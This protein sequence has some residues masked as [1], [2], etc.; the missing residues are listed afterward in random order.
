MLS[1][2]L[3]TYINPK[4]NPDKYDEEESDDPTIENE[5]EEEEEERDDLL[6]M[7]TLEEERLKIL[8]PNY[9]FTRFPVLFAQIKAGNN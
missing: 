1:N 5:E 6:P 7:V 3:S 4:Y 9:L 2:I 8:T